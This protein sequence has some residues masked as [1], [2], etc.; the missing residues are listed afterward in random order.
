MSS[1]ERRNSFIIPTR[2][3]EIFKFDWENGV[4]SRSRASLGYQFLSRAKHDFL[5]LPLEGV[6]G[7][8]KILSY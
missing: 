1:L 7:I 3:E 5:G 6:S 2:A 8:F 4:R